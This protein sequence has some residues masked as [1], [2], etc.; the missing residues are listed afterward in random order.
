MS[1]PESDSDQAVIR[2]VLV[3]LCA[4]YRTVDSTL[5]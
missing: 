5:V 2:V 4:M 3:I 1:V